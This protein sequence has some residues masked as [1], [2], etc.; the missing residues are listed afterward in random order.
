VQ[1]AGTQTVTVTLGGAT[2]VFSP[3]PNQPSSGTPFT[4]NNF[5]AGRRDLIAARS[6]I[7]QNGT[8]QLQR[9]VLRRNTAYAQA[10]TPPSINFAGPESFGPLNRFVALSN[11]AG[12][13]SSISESYQTVNG[14][15]AS[16]YESAGIFCQGA[17][18]DC[19][20]WAAVPDSLLQPGDF[21]ALFIDAAPQG[22]N[23]NTGRFA[24]LLLHAPPAA[25]A[26]SVTLGPPL[27]TA[28]VTSLGTTPNV[29]MRAQLP[30]QTAYNVA[31]GAGFSQDSSMVEVLVTAAY[32]R[33][34]PATWQIEIPDFSSAGYDAAWGLKTGVPVNWEVTALGGSVLPFLG[35]APEDGALMVGAGATG[36]PTMSMRRVWPRSWHTSLRFIA[37]PRR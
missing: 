6:T 35:A 32:L 34:L 28:S 8:T 17:A 3:P 9:M 36:S 25:G 2:T 19:V 11:L 12:D 10:A 24:G 26:A 4:L 14:V 20:P 23:V 29:R 16:F 15:S 18:V 27:T 7:L 37:A 22:S 31:A 1:N 5:P 21:H 30:S 33:G 13:E